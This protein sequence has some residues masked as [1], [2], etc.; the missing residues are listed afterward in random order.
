M[1]QQTEQL[2]LTGEVVEI[3]DHDKPHTTLYIKPFT[4]KLDDVADVRLGET[5]NVEVSIIIHSINFQS[6]IR[7]NT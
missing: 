2:S 6:T 4:I 5:A 7:R 1:T 3:V